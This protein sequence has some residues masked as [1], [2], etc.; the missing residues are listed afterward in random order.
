MPSEADYKYQISEPD[1]LNWN[2]K[3]LIWMNGRIPFDRMS[4]KLMNDKVQTYSAYNMFRTQGILQNG[5]V[6]K[7]VRL[8]FGNSQA[9]TAVVDNHADFNGVQTHENSVFL[10]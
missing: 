6:L 8:L 10:Y 4:D 3:F 2:D 5:L 1:Q 9:P 7:A